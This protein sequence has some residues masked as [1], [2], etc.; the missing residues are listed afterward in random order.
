MLYMPIAVRERRKIF[1]VFMNFNDKIPQKP[2]EEVITNLR[3]KYNEPEREKEL[4]QVC[5]SV[6]LSVCPPICLSA[7]LSVCQPNIYWC[8]ILSLGIIWL[9]FEV[10]C[11]NHILKKLISIYLL[12]K[13]LKEEKHS[14]NE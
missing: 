6:C 4:A 8:S 3:L 12:K 13:P 1:T 10:V 9:S 11:N 2:Q 7:H 5:L 14:S